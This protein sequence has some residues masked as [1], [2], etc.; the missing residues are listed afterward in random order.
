VEDLS[1]AEGDFKDHINP[2]SLEVITGYAEPSLKEATLD[3]KIQF[4]R[5]GYFCLD[6]DATPEKLI[7]NRTVGLKDTWGKVAGK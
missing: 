2:N 1:S 5:K 3:T 6:T 4:V 7:F